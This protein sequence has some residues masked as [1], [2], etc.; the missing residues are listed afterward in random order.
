MCLGEDWFL[1]MPLHSHWAHT[2]NLKTYVFHHFQK[3][4]QPLSPCILSLFSFGTYVIHMLQFL[5]LSNIFLCHLLI[6]SIFVIFSPLYCVISWDT[7]S[8][9]HILSAISNLFFN[10]CTEFLIS[11]I[12]FFIS[13]TSNWLISNVLL[14]D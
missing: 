3:K 4:F 5:I 9:S 8:S 11:V 10:L 6:L 2:F 12:I 13:M 7:Y 1:F 14:L